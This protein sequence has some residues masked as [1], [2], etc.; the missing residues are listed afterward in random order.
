[1]AQRIFILWDQEYQKSKYENM[2][3]PHSLRQER[4][5]GQ[6]QKVNK[7]FNYDDKGHFFL[8]WENLSYTYFTFTKILYK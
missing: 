3:N 2:K 7:N 8:E 6:A 1:M 4:L 5:N